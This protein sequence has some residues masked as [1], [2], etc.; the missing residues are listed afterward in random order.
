MNTFLGVSLGSPYY[1]NNRIKSYASWAKVNAD[2]FAILVGDEIYKYTLIAL[3]NMTE[4]EARARA[5][6]V[7]DDTVT[8]IERAL[9]NLDVAIIRWNDLV[10]D[11][12]NEIV[13]ACREE[14][15]NNPIFGHSVSCLL[16]T[17]PSPRD[18]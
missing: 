16:Y 2:K 6:I 15:K 11:A 3:K 10:C 4:D 1:S 12:Y 17:S 9:Y 18:S 7:G 13:K 14:I 8:N 5:F